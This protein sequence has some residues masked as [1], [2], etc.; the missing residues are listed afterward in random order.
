MLQEFYKIC[1]DM[2]PYNKEAFDAY[3]KGETDEWPEGTVYEQSDYYDKIIGGEFDGPNDTMALRIRIAHARSWEM[4]KVVKYRG[5]VRALAAIGIPIE[6]VF[7][8]CVKAEAKSFIPG[9]EAGRYYEDTAPFVDAKIK[10]TAGD[11]KYQND[12]M[13]GLFISAAIA[14]L[15]KDAEKYVRYI[16]AVEDF[17]KKTFD[18]EDVSFK[19][20]V[21]CFGFKKGLGTLSPGLQKLELRLM[22]DVCRAGYIGSKEETI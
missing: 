2:K 19:W 16:P 11:A 6:K 5:G 3:I 10:H 7:D 21:A 17:I 18:E 4:S 15:E 14:L 22:L 20:H 9:Y 1:R 13:Y 8:A 12:K